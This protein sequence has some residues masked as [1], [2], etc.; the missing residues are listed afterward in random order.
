MQREV[1][2]L[3][4]LIN[5]IQDYGTGHITEITIKMGNEEDKISRF[6]KS[7]A[8]KGKRWGNNKGSCGP[9]ED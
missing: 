5:L 3:I 7:E 6:K 4:V 8:L 1:S 2:I 9:K